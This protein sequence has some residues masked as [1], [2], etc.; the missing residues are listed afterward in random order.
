MSSSKPRWMSFYKA[1]PRW[2]FDGF[3]LVLIMF[4]NNTKCWLP[5]LSVNCTFI[6]LRLVHSLHV[7]IACSQPLN[8]WPMKLCVWSVYTCKYMHVCVCLGARARK[9]RPEV[10]TGSHPPLLFTL[11]SETGSPMNPGADWFGE[12]DSGWTPA[13]FLSPALGLQSAITPSFEHGCWGSKLSLL[14]LR[15]RHFIDGAIFLAPQMKT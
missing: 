1:L 4:N 5:T 6:F 11:F 10:N 12:T 8:I 3:Y 7:W 2:D 14:R 13:A 15:G 9:W